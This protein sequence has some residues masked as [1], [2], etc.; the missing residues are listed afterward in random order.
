MLNGHAFKSSRDFEHVDYLGADVRTTSGNKDSR[1]KMGCSLSPLGVFWAC[2]SFIVMTSSV[3]AFVTPY[4][5][6]GELVDP[7]S[8]SNV[9]TTYFGLWRRCNYY[10]FDAADGINIV[11][12][13][14]CGRYSR[15]SDIPTL[16]WK[17]AAVTM[18]VGCVINVFIGFYCLLGCCVQHIVSRSVAQALGICQFIAG[19]A[20]SISYRSY[21]WLIYFGAFDAMIW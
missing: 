20:I 11:T 18:C 5:L 9:T 2:L 4:W 8:S 14:G 1:K 16:W 13:D 17:L 15:Y 7:E 6:Q 3:L 21:F 12:V 10:A 19:N